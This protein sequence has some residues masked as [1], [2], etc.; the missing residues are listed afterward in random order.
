MM[1]FLCWKKIAKA[2][3]SSSINAM[4]SMECYKD[5]LINTSGPISRSTIT[6]LDPSSG[7]AE[8][9]GSSCLNRVPRRLLPRSNVVAALSL[10]AMNA[11]PL[12]FSKICKLIWLSWKNFSLLLTMLETFFKKLRPS[13]PWRV[14]RKL[15]FV[16]K[17]LLSLRVEGEGLEKVIYTP[18]RL[19]APPYGFLRLQCGFLQIPFGPKSTSCVL[20]TT[21]SKF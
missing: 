11:P 15:V 14:L 8:I 18:L 16:L 19:P 10:P 21:H 17:L 13:P 12:P 4:L 6:S 7:W 3:D 5:F 1:L 20:L 9:S 2:G